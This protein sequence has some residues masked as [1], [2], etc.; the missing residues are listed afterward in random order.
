VPLALT[1]WPPAAS[2][3]LLPPAPPTPLAASTA[4]P[5]SSLAASP[6]KVQLQY[7][8]LLHASLSHGLQVP[9]NKGSG[10]AWSAGFLVPLLDLH[11]RTRSEDVFAGCQAVLHE[12]LA[13]LGLQA[14]EACEVRCCTLVVRTLGLSGT[15]NIWR[16]FPAL[17]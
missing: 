17:G 12:L 8:S 11:A 16:P 3:W 1:S 10:Q 9:E 6:V 14:G 2:P 15:V 7:L 13:G 4:Q 5:P